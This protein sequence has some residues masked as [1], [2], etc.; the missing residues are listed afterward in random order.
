MKIDL[1]SMALSVRNDVESCHCIRH[2][3][4][5]ANFVNVIIPRRHIQNGFFQDLHLTTIY[6]SFFSN[7]SVK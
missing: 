7:F 2:I 5:F 1:L 6:F 4:V 3:N